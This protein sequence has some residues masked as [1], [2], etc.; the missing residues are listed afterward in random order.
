[1]TPSWREYI[2][3]RG[4]AGNQ[5]IHP[6]HLADKLASHLKRPRFQLPKHTLR[7]LPWFN[8]PVHSPQ[9]LCPENLKHGN[10]SIRSNQMLQ[11]ELVGEDR[12]FLHLLNKHLRWL[13]QC[14]PRYNEE[15]WDGA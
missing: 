14:S 15:D 12:P 13:C 5:G 1:M 8:S 2:Q 9:G 7:G 3:F 10:I 4:E 6:K 11:L